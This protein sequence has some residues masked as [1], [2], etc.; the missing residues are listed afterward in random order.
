MV[1]GKIEGKRKREWQR[2]RWSDSITDSMGKS[3]Q[4]SGDTGEQ[5]ALACCGPWSRRVGHDL[6]RKQWQQGSTYAIWYICTSTW[7]T[8]ISKELHSHTIPIRSLCGKV[9]VMT[10]LI[11]KVA[12]ASGMVPDYGGLSA[13]FS[14]WIRAEWPSKV[15]SSGNRNEKERKR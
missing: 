14:G 5:R 15:N 2:I 11:T 10:V 9:V 1:L 3:E 7:L 8:V 6:A 13:T 4:T 12:V